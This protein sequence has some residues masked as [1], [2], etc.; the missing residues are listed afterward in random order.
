MLRWAIHQPELVVDW[1]DASLFVDP[2][3][4]EAFE[5]LWSADELHEAIEGAEGPRERCSSAWRSRNRRPT[6]SRRRCGPGSW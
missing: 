6:P 5:H 2:I 3:A 4:R 1:L